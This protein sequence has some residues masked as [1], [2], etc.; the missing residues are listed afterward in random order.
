MSCDSNQQ[1]HNAGH[2][3]INAIY[4]SSETGRIFLKGEKKIRLHMNR[5]LI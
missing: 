3:S 1:T 4:A 5:I 2:V